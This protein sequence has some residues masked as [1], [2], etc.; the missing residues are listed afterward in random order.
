LQYP[1]ATALAGPLFRRC[2]LLALDFG[3]HNRTTVLYV[4]TLLTRGGTLMTLDRPPTDRPPT[5]DSRP[6]EPR[7]DRSLTLHLRGDWGM[8][9]LHRVCGWI[10]QELTDRCGPYTR[11]AIWNSRGFCDAVRAVGRGEVDIALTTP[12]AFT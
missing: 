1:A 12:A 10:S 4:K 2:E 5:P 8:A 7:I 6:P 3:Q 9:N 11:V